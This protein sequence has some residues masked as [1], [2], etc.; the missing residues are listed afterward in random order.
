MQ[1]RGDCKAHVVGR[2]FLHFFLLRVLCA[3]TPLREQL[4]ITA[5]VEIILKKS[6]RKDTKAPRTQRE[7][8]EH[9]AAIRKSGK[10][11]IPA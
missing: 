8:K 9:L 11:I 3:A 1:R 2:K 7:E 4:R 6:S 10:V 5:F